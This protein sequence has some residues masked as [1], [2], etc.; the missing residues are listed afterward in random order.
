VDHL[1][2]LRLAPHL[3][4]LVGVGNNVPEATNR[5]DAYI[6][7]KCKKGGEYTSMRER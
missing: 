6:Q 2:V 4:S 1:L 3:V 5:G 7:F